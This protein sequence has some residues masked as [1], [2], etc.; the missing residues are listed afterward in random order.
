ML[1]A[2]ERAQA[3]HHEL[4]RRLGPVFA[5]REVWAQAGKYIDG[6]ASD[7]PRKNGWTIAEHAG[8]RSPDKTQR[9]LNHA[10]WDEHEAM[11]VVRDFVVEH[12]GD[13]DAVAV[14]DETGQEKKG[15]RTCGV[16]PQYVGCAGQVANAVNVV[17]C[18]Y[19]SRRGHAQVGARLY[20]PEE[21]AADPARR[22]RAG[23]PE[24][25]E[26]NT[27]PELGIDI[28][29]DLHAA[30]A[31]PPWV[32]ADE[33]YGRDPTL[34]TWCEDR[35]VGYALGVPRSF[36]VVLTSGRKVRADQALGFV[37]ATAWNR[38]SCGPGSKGDRTYDWAWIATAS[39]RHHLLIRRS[40]TDPTDQAFFY[41]HVPED[42]PTTLG[43]MVKIAGRR[44]PVEED[45]QFGKDHFG[46]DH[47]QVRLYTALTRH[48]TLAMASLA[49][50]AVTAAQMRQATSTLPPAPTSPDDQPPE[51]PGLIPLTVA[52]VKRLYN[53]LT[54]RCHHLS[55][56]L[57]WA[58]WRRRHQARARWYH[59]RS[60][61]R[62]EEAT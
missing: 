18:T 35:N 2:A 23:V 51:D 60:R 25:V 36:T 61:L 38:A 45:F 26:F 58:W 28:L 29:A 12:L 47:S 15:E 52:E 14:L 24:D 6:L 42:R 21:W 41:C 39:P 32:T 16:K 50:A 5:R 33:V 62:R 46:L 4:A 57:R 37:P 40:L 56:H 1:E 22:D 53:L 17:Y 43:T 55:H 49:I 13:P 31:L 34:R 20:L 10:V 27:K 54:R 44:W 9:L 7:I 11:S 3:N 8:D 48:L 30:G 19:A 59:Q